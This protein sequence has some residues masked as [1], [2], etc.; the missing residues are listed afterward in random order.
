MQVL[1]RVPGDETAEEEGHPRGEV[2]QR[3]P[4]LRARGV[5]FRR[6]AHL[7]SVVPLLA[8]HCQGHIMSNFEDTDG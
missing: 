2:H 5:A 8:S 1:H 3:V 4:R 7:Q 6:R